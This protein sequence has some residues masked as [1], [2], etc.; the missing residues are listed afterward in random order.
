MKIL[1]KYQ[2]DII[3]MFFSLICLIWL[4]Y[5]LLKYF[6]ADPHDYEWFVAGPLILLYTIYL[7]N[8]RKKIQ[9]SDR[10]ALNGKTLIY[11]SLLGISI[12]AGYNNPIS[13]RDYWTINLFFLVFTLFLADS[14]WDF[15]KIS[16]RSLYFNKKNW[17]RYNKSKIHP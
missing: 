12:F 6:G 14:Y 10:R 8:I 2:L 1:R 5:Y 15:R 13:V 7:L 11:W 3:F 9:L 16:F 4:S 17:I